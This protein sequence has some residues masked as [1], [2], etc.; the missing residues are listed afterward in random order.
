MTIAEK[1]TSIGGVSFWPSGLKCSVVSESHVPCWV[2][3]SVYI[4]QI[5]PTTHIGQIDSRPYDQGAGFS[6]TVVTVVRNRS[7]RSP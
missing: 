5:W 6:A 3:R 2:Q 7:N 4:T 1:S